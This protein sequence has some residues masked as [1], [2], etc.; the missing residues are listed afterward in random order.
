MA[1]KGKSKQI[2]IVKSQP[3]LNSAG[4][5]DN[6][7]WAREM[8]WKYDRSKIRAP[9][10]RIKE[11]DY[12]YVLSDDRKYG[13]TFTLADLSYLGLVAV[14]WLD[15]EKGTSTQYDTMTLL[16]RG[17]LGLGDDPDSGSVHFKD[18]KISLSYEVSDR[19]RL[20][21]VEAPVFKAGTHRGLTGEIILEEPEQDSICIATS[22]AEN[23]R[24]FYL[25]QK[26]NCLPAL[27]RV[28]IGSNEYRFSPADSFGGLDWGRGYWT[29]R[30]R[31]YWGSA[32]GL[33]NGVPSG[34]NIGYG[35]SDRSPA[36]ENVIFYNH[37]AHKIDEV[38]FHIP[39]ES[40]TAPW[41]FSS[42]DGRFVMD[43]A[44][45][46]D[47]SSSLNLGLLKSVQ[48]QV[49]GHFTGKVVLDDGKEIRVNR[50]LGFAEDVLNWW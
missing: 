20:I 22:W 9:W 50:F 28:Q 14:C 6:E 16:P 25:N 44:P 48:H 46:L 34:W 12:Y 15:F 18:G 3:L 47:R 32:S 33:L 11:W 13:I 4:R 26:T 2:E 39:A 24:A 23:R 29:Y 42:S 1:G 7:G 38:F 8:H 36:S 40:Y 35:F 5:I 49:F 19:K 10:H 41:Q 30:N 27:G 21:K 45:I 37:R 17:H 31:W 43:F